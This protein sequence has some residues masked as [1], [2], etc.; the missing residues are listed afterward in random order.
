MDLVNLKTENVWF[1]IAV[2]A[3]AHLA[4]LLVWLMAVC[5]SREK[6][7]AERFQCVF[8][9]CSVQ[10]KLNRK[11]HCACCIQRCAN[12]VESVRTPLT[13]PK[14][15]RWRSA[16]IIHTPHSCAAANFRRALTAGLFR[17]VAEL[18]TIAAA[19]WYTS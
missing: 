15:D 12:R 1:W 5:C 11:T 3:A 17:K 18:P 13:A 6:T 10:A 8:H 9:L 7:E 19:A 14:G 16:I 4:V 2:I